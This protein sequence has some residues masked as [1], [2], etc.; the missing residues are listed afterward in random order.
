MRKG[1]RGVQLKVA[2]GRF[3]F[4]PPGGVNIIDVEDVAEATISSIENGRNGERYILAGENI[5]IKELF[6]TIAKIS[7]AKIPRLP[8]TSSFLHTLGKVG[9]LLEKF[10]KKGP[11]NSETAWTSTLYHWFDSEKAQKELGLKVTPASSAIE[12]SI[13]WAKENGML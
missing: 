6:Q 7:G 5:L 4:Y 1:S 9:D 13:A 10:D 11:V 12:K 3:P 8:L 2:Q